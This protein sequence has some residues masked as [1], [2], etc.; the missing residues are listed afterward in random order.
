MLST[1]NQ[2]HCASAEVVLVTAALLKNW[3]SW[4]LECQSLKTNGLLK[5]SCFWY[6]ICCAGSQSTAGPGYAVKC[7]ASV[8][9]D[10]LIEGVLLSQALL[11][12]AYRSTCKFPVAFVAILKLSAQQRLVWSRPQPITMTSSSCVI[13]TFLPARCVLQPQEA[14]QIHAHCSVAQTAPAKL[15]LRLCNLSHIQYLFQ[16][17]WDRRDSCQLP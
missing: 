16:V 15:T 3:N 10:M 9:N 12:K 6:S 13:R 8:S 11:T 1:I 14:A 4:Q 7:C 17:V 2:P 5:F